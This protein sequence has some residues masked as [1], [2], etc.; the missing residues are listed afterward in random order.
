MAMNVEQEISDL[1]RRVAEGS[2]TY[3]VGQLR[4][5]QTHMH[6]QFAEV[7]ADVASL[8]KDLLGIVSDAIRSTPRPG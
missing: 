7:R 5:V 3:I 8:H 6:A 1:K 4:E 2:F